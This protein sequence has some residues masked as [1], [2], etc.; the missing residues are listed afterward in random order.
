MKNEGK[1]TS[2]V[3]LPARRWYFRKRFWLLALLV[4]FVVWLIVPSTFS[5]GKIRF[6][7]H[8]T[9][10]PDTITFLTDGEPTKGAI[11]D[12]D[13]LVEWYTGLNRYA[14]V[15]THTV[16]FGTIGIDMPLLH[17]LAEQNGG[18]FTLVPELKQ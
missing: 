17:R 6:S 1:S 8:Y 13:T 2:A 3:L 12:G 5:K 14:R 18:K 4:L 9:G 10:T 16:T 11:T 7:I 15:V